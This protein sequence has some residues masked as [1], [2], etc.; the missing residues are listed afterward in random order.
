M[1]DLLPAPAGSLYYTPL[2]SQARGSGLATQGWILG[3]MWRGQ[4]L[5]IPFLNVLKIACRFYCDAPCRLNNLNLSRVKF[6]FFTLSYK[7]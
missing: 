6:V 1:R 2:R 7:G 3:D 5:D 4:H